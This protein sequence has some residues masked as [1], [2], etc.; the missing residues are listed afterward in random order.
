MDDKSRLVRVP[1]DFSQLQHRLLKVQDEAAKRGA[2]VHYHMVDPQAP[3]F[4]CS[5]NV[6]Q[7]IVVGSDG[8]ISPCVFTC[9]P[10]LGENYYYFRGQKQ[11]QQNLS[12]GNIQ[13]EDL[14]FIWHRKAY[15]EFV[16]SHNRWRAP[17]VCRNCY[18]GFVG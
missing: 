17:A 9:M 1:E 12:F 15:K 2:E 11:I 16:R 6:A 14:N 18:K 5:E 8:N 10:V 3:H 13:T 7:A 4:K